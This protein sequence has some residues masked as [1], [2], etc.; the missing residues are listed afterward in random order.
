MNAMRLPPL[1]ARS[2]G[3]NRLAFRADG[4]RLAT[5]DTALNVAVREGS[6]PLWSRSLASS[7][8]KVAG[9]QRVRGLAYAP[10]GAALYAL[11]SDRLLAL[12]AE[13]GESL[14]SYTPSR[15]LGF[16]VTSAM[17]VAIREDGL[18]A[19]SFD[20][21]AIGTWS[22]QGE[23]QGTYIPHTQNRFL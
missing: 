6:R 3:L 7:D 9:V 19:A 15:A 21:G 5:A 22:A 12:D 20:N 23:I 4:V 16:L 17:A 8:P 18:V 2:T 11:A 10:D 14:W 13:T 1:L